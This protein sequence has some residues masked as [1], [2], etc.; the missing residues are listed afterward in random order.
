[1]INN[2][3]LEYYNRSSFQSLFINHLEINQENYISPLN[4]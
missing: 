1:M 3:S 4:E 2:N